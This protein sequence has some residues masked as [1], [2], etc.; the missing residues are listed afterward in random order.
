MRITLIALTALACIAL[1][2]WWYLGGSKPEIIPPE[3]PRSPSPTFIDFN[4]MMR[5][6][7]EIDRQI[8]VYNN[9]GL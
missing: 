7:K 1:A 5:T 8:S 4:E 9:P 2:Y 6:T 3:P